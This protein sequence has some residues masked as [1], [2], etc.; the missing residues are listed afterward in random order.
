MSLLRRDFIVAAGSGA[1]AGF[2]GDAWGASDA[3]D[4]IADRGP[5]A[6]L[7]AG[8]AAVEAPRLAVVAGDQPFVAPALVTRLFERA[9]RDDAGGDE[10]AAVLATVDGEPD[11][12]HAVYPTAAVERAG[13]RL[14]AEGTRR[15]RALVA[16]LE[17]V[18]TRP[19]DADRRCLFDVDT[20][21]DHRRARAAAAETGGEVE[22]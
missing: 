14:L 18:E 9:E 1:V 4:P 17:R 2:V 7:V 19:A 21:A 15:L 5:L 13:R 8:A 16:A 12:T 11:P 22:P 3:V 10:P 20:P 6:G